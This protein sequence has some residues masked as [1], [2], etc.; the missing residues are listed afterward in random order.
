MMAT[1]IPIIY[2]IFFPN[3]FVATVVKTTI[4]IELNGIKIAAITGF[5]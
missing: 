4:L 5:N 1:F 2:F 3:K